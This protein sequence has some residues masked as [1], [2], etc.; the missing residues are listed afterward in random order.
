MRALLDVSVLIALLDA[1]HAHHRIATDWLSANITEGWASCPI[2]QTGYVRVVSQPAYPRTLP[3]ADAMSRLRDATQTP[4]H[5]LWPDDVPPLDPAHIDGTRMLGPNQITDTYLI[6]L[7]AH[8][9]GTF[10]TLDRRTATTAVPT[11][12]PDTLTKL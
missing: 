11:A 2:T 8:H 5:E 1:N 10:V 3:V 9:N 4:H 6:A 7:A 12:L